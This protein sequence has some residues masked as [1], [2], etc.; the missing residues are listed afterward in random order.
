MYVWLCLAHLDY[1]YMMD[2]CF[3]L[4]YSDA[5]DM[6]YGVCVLRMKGGLDISTIETKKGKAVLY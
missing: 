4:L 1:T 6:N 3:V 5:F 2:C